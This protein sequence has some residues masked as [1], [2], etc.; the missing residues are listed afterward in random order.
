MTTN[1]NTNPW[2][3]VYWNQP[4]TGRGAV[5][6]NGHV[7]LQAGDAADADAIVKDELPAGT[8]IVNTLGPYG[9]QTAAAAYANS[10]TTSP[11]GTTTSGNADNIPNPLAGLAAIGAFFTSLGEAN[12]WIR[13]A[14][15][16]IGGALV[17]IGLAH[18]TGAD[19]A[20]ASFA[21]K[22]PLPI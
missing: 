8:V 9:T 3:I 11:T 20:V 21:R 2:F 15:V 1:V 18:L 4:Q 6:K 5:A 17:L 14:K 10:P 13:V 12:T 19:N 22:A 7:T 16:V